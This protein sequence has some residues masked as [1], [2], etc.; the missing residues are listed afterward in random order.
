MLAPMNRKM[1]YISAATAGIATPLMRRFMPP[2]YA[3]PALVAG[4]VLFAIIV[5][6][7]RSRQLRCQRGEP[8]A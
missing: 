7:A 6:W 1:L 3:L 8:Q 4:L 2:Q 5:L